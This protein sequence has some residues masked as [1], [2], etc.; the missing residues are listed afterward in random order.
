MSE[1]DDITPEITRLMSKAER[2]FTNSPERSKIV[3]MP[4]AGKS[5]STSEARLAAL[6]A[7]GYP[8]R[9]LMCLGSMKGAGEIKARELAPR[10]LA[11]GILIVHGLTGRGKTVMAA[12]WGMRRLEAGKDCGKFLTAHRIFTDM[13]SAMSLK[14]DPAAIQKALEKAAFLVI[15]EA[16][17]RGESPWENAIMDEVVNARYNAMRPTVLIGNFTNLEETQGC[18]GPRIMDRANECGGVVSCNW[19]SYR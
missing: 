16:Q 1:H 19:P 11:D 8:P 14:K 10:L 18:L 3:G 12:Y 4:A 13:K 17:T 15:D 9:A 5:G 6:E 7:A 2:A